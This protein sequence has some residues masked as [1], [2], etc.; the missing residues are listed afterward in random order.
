V[1]IQDA[2]R[3]A[4]DS[5]AF[6]PG[7]RLPSEN[8]LAERYATTRVTVAHALQALVYEG[9]IEKR[10][11]SGT[12]VA[13]APYASSLDTHSLAYFER[14]V[15]ARGQSVAYQVLEFAPTPTTPAIAAALRLGR[16][17]PVFRLLRLRLVEGHPL[18][19]ERRYVA[20]LLAA[21]LPVEELQTRAIQ[22]VFEDRLG[23][24]VARISNSVRAALVPRELAKPLQIPAARPV[25]VR[26]HTL[27]DAA[28]APLLWGET[29]YREEYRI[30][31]SLDPT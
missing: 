8:E 11:G 23:R 5:G 21:S 26:E 22:E 29:F 15:F 24:P 27:L 4:I 28:G 2:L 31:Y 12:Y 16:R 30:V 13:Q 18:A 20:A 10:R 3:A 19:I 7:D 25:L 6:K 17:E 1:R 14:D 9:L